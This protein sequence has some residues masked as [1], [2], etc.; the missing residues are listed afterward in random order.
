MFIPRAAA[1]ADEAQ[2]PLALKIPCSLREFDKVFLEKVYLY[3]MNDPNF[4][5]KLRDGLYVYAN[6][7]IVSILNQTVVLLTTAQLQRKNKANCKVCGHFLNKGNV[8]GWNKFAS[9]NTDGPN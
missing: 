9:W 1:N 7:C 6:I 4:E 8:N 5:K 2:K 3:I